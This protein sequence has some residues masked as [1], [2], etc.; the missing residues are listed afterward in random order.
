MKKKNI[1]LCIILSLVTCGIYG[2][3]W[4]FCMAE[5]LNSLSRRGNETSG[6][7]VVVFNI[8]TCGIYG[9]YWAYKS[10]ELLDQ[11]RMNR[12]VVQGHLGIVYCVLS[13]LKLEIVSFA[14][15]QS[16]LNEYA[17]E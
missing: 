8:L 15:I 13:L 9:I 10:G 2:W 5:D 14:L 11:L 3:Y 1:A 6:G 16:E 7:L 4:L 17:E 12:G